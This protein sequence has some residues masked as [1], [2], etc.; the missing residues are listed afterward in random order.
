MNVNCYMKPQLFSTF[1]NVLT[2]LSK[3]I[4][5]QINCIRFVGIVHESDATCTDD[6]KIHT[7]V[8]ICHL[9]KKY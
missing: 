9:K 4:S 3:Y 2:Y 1:R 5:R 7:A 8:H 6:I